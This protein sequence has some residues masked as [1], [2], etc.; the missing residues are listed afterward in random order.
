MYNAAISIGTITT[1]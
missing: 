1:L